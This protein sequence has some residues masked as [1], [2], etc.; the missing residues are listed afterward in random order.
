VEEFNVRSPKEGI[1]R[2][3]WKSSLEFVSVSSLRFKA[4]QPLLAVST[5][6]NQLAYFPEFVFSRVIARE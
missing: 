5:N 4:Y 3:G 1:V 2:R 6:R